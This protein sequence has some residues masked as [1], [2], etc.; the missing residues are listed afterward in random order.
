MHNDARQVADAH[1]ATIS[2]QAMAIASSASEQI[3]QLEALFD[4]LHEQLEDGTYARKLAELGRQASS[5][6]AFELAEIAG[7]EA[8]HA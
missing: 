3:S 2:K 1:N 8:A 4:A 7:S 6:Y 5:R